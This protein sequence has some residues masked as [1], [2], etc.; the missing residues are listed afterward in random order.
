VSICSSSY[1]DDEGKSDLRSVPDHQEIFLSR[2]TLSNLI[3][4]IN[5]RVATSTLNSTT[6]NPQTGAPHANAQT[7]GIGAAL[8]HLHDLCEEGDSMDVVNSPHPVALKHH[9][10]GSQNVSAFAGLVKFTSPKK[11]RRQA[12]GEAQTSVQVQQPGFASIDGDDLASGSGTPSQS[13]TSSCHFLLV[14]LPAQETD[15]LVFV[16][17]PHDEFDLQG[18]PGALS[19]EDDLASTLIG[20]F[21]ETLEVRDWDLFG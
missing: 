9:L 4:E 3:I 1:S 16:N 20:K 12:D 18:D 11:T 6:T 17:V 8:Y 7:D 14:R 5:E 19:R 13:S 10:S 2:T 21:V 15:L